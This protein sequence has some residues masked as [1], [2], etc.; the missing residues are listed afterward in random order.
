LLS[1]DGAAKI[2]RYVFTLRLEV[3][4]QLEASGAR[5]IDSV[6]WGHRTPNS[7][8]GC[9]DLPLRRPSQLELKDVV[10]GEEHTLALTG[11]LDIASCPLLVAT[12]LQIC[13]EGAGALVMDLSGVTF[14][15]STGLRALLS[16]KGLCARHGCE[17]L[18]IPGPAQVQ[19]LFELTG[20]LDR[21]PFGTRDS[22][23]DVDSDHRQNSHGTGATPEGLAAPAPSPRREPD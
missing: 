19:H 17:F 14:M 7:C 10:R 5:G 15:G 8:P 6:A 16:A 13:S 23:S 1:L 20:V 21:L 4:G 11:E 22:A 12:V 18:L 3:R 9:D 2:R